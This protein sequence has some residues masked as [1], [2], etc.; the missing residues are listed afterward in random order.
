MNEVELKSRNKQQNTEKWVAIILKIGVWTSG[1]LMISGLVIAAI[2][3]STITQFSEN[4]SLGNLFASLFSNNIN[5]VALMFTGLIVLMFT[6][7]LRVLMA[8]I[9]FS[10]ERDW[11]FMIV[12]LIVLLMLIGEIIYSIFI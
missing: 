5:S 1:L 12:S 8:C 6:P 11:R 10:I 3:P 4:P 7:I 2:L 9:G